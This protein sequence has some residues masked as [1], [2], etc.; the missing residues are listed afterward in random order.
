MRRRLETVRAGYGLIM[1]ALSWGLVACG[2]SPPSESSPKRAEEETIL[3]VV[4]VC[5]A[6][7][8]GPDEPCCN[9]CSPQGWS[10]PEG[11]E[12]RPA[13]GVAMPRPE[14]DG[15][16]RSPSYKAIGYQEGNVFFISSWT[17]FSEVR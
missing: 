8:C 14:V 11:V 4:P 3:S 10:I 7:E 9:A 16:G 2:S 1:L 12:V 17:P 15:C 13:P 5:T 6:S